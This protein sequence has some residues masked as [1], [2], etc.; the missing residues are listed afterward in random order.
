MGAV[1]AKQ[2][3]K[4]ISQWAKDRAKIL[5]KSGTLFAYG[6]LFHT[7]FDLAPEL[8]PNTTLLN[9]IPST[10][11]GGISLALHSRHQKNE[12]DGTDN[13]VPEKCLVKAHETVRQLT[14]NTNTNNNTS[15]CALI[16]LSDRD[17]T[18]D[19]LAQKAQSLNC[20]HVKAEHKQGTFFLKEHGPHAGIGFWQDLALASQAT[21]AFVSTKHSSA[22]DLFAISLRYQRAKKGLT[23]KTPLVFCIIDPENKGDCP[24]GIE[25]EGEDVFFLKFG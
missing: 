12:D 25:K 21:G 15:S 7:A 10:D 20:S 9:Q 18:V 23:A 19:L 22:S 3:T 5:F 17:V 2:D 4:S 14:P 16:A 13:T 11:N 24:C 8:L 1:F 6:A